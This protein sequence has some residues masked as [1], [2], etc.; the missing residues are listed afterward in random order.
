MSD[1]KAAAARLMATPSN[2]WRASVARRLAILGCTYD[3]L[4]TM[5][6]ADDFISPK[7]AQLWLLIG[8]SQDD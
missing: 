4:R 8:G 7:H 2:A 3:E 6:A 5:A 1:L